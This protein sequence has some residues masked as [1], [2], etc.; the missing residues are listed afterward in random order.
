MA[1]TN[2]LANQLEGSELGPLIELYSITYGSVEFNITPS[3]GGF[4]FDGKTYD[5]FPIEIEGIE[6]T[7]VGASPR[8]VVTVANIQS[9]FDENFKD[10][11]RKVISA[12]TSDPVMAALLEDTANTTLQE[13]NSADGAKFAAKPQDELSQVVADAD[14][15]ELFGEA[16][17]NWAHLAFSDA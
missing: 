2:V 14:P 13:Q 4:T 7:Q 16:S 3:E 1:F 10:N 11:T 12:A 8:P 5:Q 15:S 6:K 9:L 17:N